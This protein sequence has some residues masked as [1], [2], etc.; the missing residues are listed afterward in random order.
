MR[1]GSLPKKKQQQKKGKKFSRNFEP[2]FPLQSFL[3]LHSCSCDSL[4]NSYLNKNRLR[5]L[6]RQ[7]QNLLLGLTK[8]CRPFVVLLLLLLHTSDGIFSKALQRNND[9]VMCSVKLKSASNQL[10]RQKSF[11]SSLPCYLFHLLWLILAFQTA[12]NCPLS[13]VRRPSASIRCIRS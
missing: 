13:L 1:D 5:L 8:L 4:R 11:T 3:S 9:L 7:I 12:S 2:F 10:M 6:R